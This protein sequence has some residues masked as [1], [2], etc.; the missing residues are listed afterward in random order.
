MNTLAPTSRRGVRRVGSILLFAILFVTTAAALQAQGSAVRVETFSLRLNGEVVVENARGSTR[1]E[2]WDFQT[3]RV[4]AE[5]KGAAG[6]SLE[7]GELVLMGAQNSVIVQCRQGFGRIDLTIY[8]PNSARLQVTG[9]GWPV[10]IGGKLASAVIDTTSGSIA[11]RLPS[12]DDARVAMRSALGTVRSTF[13]LTAVERIGTHSLQGQTGSGAAQVILNSQ[14]GN[15]TLTPGP[16]SAAVAKASSTEFSPAANTQVSQVATSAESETDRQTRVVQR[17]PGNSAAMKGEPAQQDDPAASD[18]G[19]TRQAVQSNGSVVFAG[20]D[21]SDDSSLTQTSGPFTRPRSERKTSSGDSGLK[22]RII[23]SNA[24]PRAPRN[25]AGSVFDQTND[26]EETKQGN[27]SAN[28]APA[29]I[30]FRILRTDS[31]ERK[32]V[33]LCGGLVAPPML[34]ATGASPAGSS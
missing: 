19:A 31:P 13:P 14:N 15:V 32:S 23:P 26:E 18:P 20:S 25:A 29:K 8:V 22:V 21:R 7:P 11:Y 1:V 3:V 4:V 17:A 10:D 28:G 9:G 24:S 16:N 34:P 33:S 2:A 27:T 5:K 6:N 12:N 30:N